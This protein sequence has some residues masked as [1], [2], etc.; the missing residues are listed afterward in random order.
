MMDFEK[1]H[2]NAF[3]EIFPNS[4]ISS[5]L[6]HLSQNIFRKVCE[7]GYKEQYHKDFELSLLIR[8]FAAL[9]FL[10]IND[11]VD[12]FEELIGNEEIPQE[13][14]NYFEKNYIGSEKGRGINKRRINPIFPFI[15]WNV[16][17][18]TLSNMP[19]TNNHCE[20]YHNAIQNGISCS[21]PTIWTLI[22]YLKK[23]EALVVLKIVQYN[24]GDKKEQNKKYKDITENL[25]ELINRY[26]PEDKMVFLK[27]CASVLKM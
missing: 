15:T 4:E 18:R 22:D 1:G 3:K 11:V 9:S 23:E 26:N 25:K 24:R 16:R 19:R 13:I 8:C 7:F 17:E 27:G 12:G 6:F 5:C 20:G 10:P 14:I 2:I 21:H